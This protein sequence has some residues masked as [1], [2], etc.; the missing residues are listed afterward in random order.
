[1]SELRETRKEDLKAENTLQ[2]LGHAKTEYAGDRSG[3]SSAPCLSSLLA[4]LDPPIRQSWKANIFPKLCELITELLMKVCF[5]DASPLKSPV[6]EETENISDNATP[7][8][9]AYVKMQ[10]M[11]DYLALYN[12][13]ESVG[14]ARLARYFDTPPRNNRFPSVDQARGHIIALGE[15]ILQLINNT[16]EGLGNIRELISRLEKLLAK[17]KEERDGKTTVLREGTLPSFEKPTGSLCLRLI[18]E[19]IRQEIQGLN[20]IDIRHELLQAATIEVRQHGNVDRGA[21]YLFR[22][23]LGCEELLSFTDYETLSSTSDPIY[24]SAGEHSGPEMRLTHPMRIHSEGRNRRQPSKLRHRRRLSDAIEFSQLRLPSSTK[25]KQPNLTFLRSLWSMA[26]D[27]T[28]AIR[29]TWFHSRPPPNP[30]F[31]GSGLSTFTVLITARENRLTSDEIR[32][33]LEHQDAKDKEVEE[34]GA[35]GLTYHLS[36]IKVSETTLPE[37]ILKAIRKAVDEQ[38]LPQPTVLMQGEVARNDFHDRRSLQFTSALLES[39]CRGTVYAN[40][41]VNSLAEVLGPSM[42]TLIMDEFFESSKRWFR[43]HSAPLPYTKE[44]T[45]ATSFISAHYRRIK[46]VCNGPMA[47]E[48]LPSWDLIQPLLDRLLTILQDLRGEL[49]FNCNPE[50]ELRDRII[51]GPLKRRLRVAQSPTRIYSR[52]VDTSVSLAPLHILCYVVPQVVQ[53][54]LQE[55]EYDTGQANDS[56]SLNNPRITM[57]W[58]TVR[59][60]TMYNSPHFRVGRSSSAGREPQGLPSTVRRMEPTI[61][62]NMGDTDCPEHINIKQ[63][64]NALGASKTTLA[65]NSESLADVNLARKEHEAGIAETSKAPG[66][67]SSDCKD[68][69]PKLKRRITKD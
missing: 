53:E 40:T 11:E 39:L 54:E 18:L 10:L 41:K 36:R 32:A 50:T 5:L 37:D 13:K 66:I 6:L 56:D 17:A 44:F 16:A 8:S 20:G 12:W 49:E 58:E 25:M 55:M 33:A 2:D 29:D 34:D 60:D 1:M 35:S 46:Q 30:G 23:D 42:Q 9:W 19:G 59:F 51:E 63:D 21:P 38:N 24:F 47:N 57:S 15:R 7:S 45:E 48:L 31:L 14:S 69:N 67:S 27:T 4:Q 28:T 62:L 65:D 68:V 64:Q 52:S 61:D 26:Q 43:N 22:L 3:S